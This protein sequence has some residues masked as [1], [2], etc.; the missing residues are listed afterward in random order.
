[1]FIKFFFHGYNCIRGLRNKKRTEKKE[2][3]SKVKSKACEPFSVFNHLCENFVIF[4]PFSFA[5]SISTNTKGDGLCCSYCVKYWRRSNRN[6][7]LTIT[8][9]KRTKKEQ[10]NVKI[11]K[12]F[13]S[14]F[15]ER[16]RKFGKKQMHKKSVEYFLV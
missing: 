6:C 7:R 9:N 1:M 15:F 14:F 2:R 4:F 8:K 5:H 13:L 11:E 16:Y 10:K 3:K 12:F